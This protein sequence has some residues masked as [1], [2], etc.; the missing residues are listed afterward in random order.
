MVQL[1]YNALAKCIQQLFF[2]NFVDIFDANLRTLIASDY[3]YNNDSTSDETV[4]GVSDL[5]YQVCNTF[6][7]YESAC[8]K[9]IYR[10][11]FLDKL[12][13]T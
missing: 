3:Y 5:K 9:L 6:M 12:P 4:T 11:Y 13:N 7:H 2:F 10:C 1:A 8:N